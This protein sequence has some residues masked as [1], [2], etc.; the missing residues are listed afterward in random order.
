MCI[1]RLHIHTHIQ[2]TTI[3]NTYIRTQHTQT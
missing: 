1:V 3:T 2:M